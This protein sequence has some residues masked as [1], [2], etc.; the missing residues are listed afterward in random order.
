MQGCGHRVDRST[1]PGAESP[2]CGYRYK[3]PSLPKGDYTVTAQTRWLV[4]W[5]INGVSG[6]IPVVQEATTAL[7]VGELQSLVR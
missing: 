3:K 1:P 2:T 5:T 7:P 4:D 6:S